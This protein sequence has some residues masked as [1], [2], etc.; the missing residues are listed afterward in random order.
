MFLKMPGVQKRIEQV[1]KLN[2]A[3]TLESVNMNINGRPEI[4]PADTEVAELIKLYERDVAANRHY[5]DKPH[6][7]K[8]DRTMLGDLTKLLKGYEE[9]AEKDDD[10][11]PIYD[12]GQVANIRRFISDEYQI[13]DQGKN[14][15][16]RKLQKG[17]LEFEA[18]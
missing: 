12:M 3:P 8:A 7:E 13:K 2:L 18:E 11:N 9:R 6:P 17:T 5:V 15:L 1:E 16:F 10:G 14:P 4:M